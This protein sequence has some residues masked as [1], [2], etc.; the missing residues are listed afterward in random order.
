MMATTHITTAVTSTSA[1]AVPLAAAGVNPGICLMTI[2]IGAYSVLFPDWDHHGSRITSSLPPLSNL[3]SWVIR[4]GPFSTPS[5]YWERSLFSIPVPRFDWIPRR[6]FP[7]Y[8]PHRGPL[9]TEE[10]ALIF[11]LLL[12]L[13]LWLLP[14]PIGTYWWAFAI[15]ITV[16]CL[17]HL[18]GDMRTTGGLQARGGAPTDR[19]TIGDPFDVGSK[20]ETRLREHVYQPVAIGAAAVSTVAVV[21]LAGGIT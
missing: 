13:P 6:V 9:H 19:R 21:Y 12:G 1:M 15:Q 16:G 8:V 17:T 3:V 7:W 5:L 18:W 11:G 10:A 20:K 14:D 2:P 4:G